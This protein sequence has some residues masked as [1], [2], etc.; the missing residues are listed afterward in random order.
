MKKSTS[1]ILGTTFFLFFGPIGI[2]IFV[3]L[4]KRALAGKGRSYSTKDFRGY[5]Q[6]G[7]RFTNGTLTEKPLRDAILTAMEEELKKRNIPAKVSPAAVASRK[8]FAFN[9]M[10]ML[11]IKNTEPGKKYFDMGIVVNY[12]TVTFPLLGESKENTRNNMHNMYKN[13]RTF[14]GDV[15]SMFYRADE[16]KLQSEANWQQ[17]VLDCFAN[18]V[19]DE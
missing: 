2:L 9:W 8:I 5:I 7:I 6:E 4:Y 11:V 17:D 18:A 16:F 10:P 3:L 12:N 14:S 19:L 1:I 15:K 13:E